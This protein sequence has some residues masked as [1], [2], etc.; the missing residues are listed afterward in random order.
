MAVPPDSVVALE[1]TLNKWSGTALIIHSNNCSIVR[2]Q[3]TFVA[4]SIFSANIILLHSGAVW[5]I[6]EW[7]IFS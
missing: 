2:E 6:L 5:G 4:R 7:L 3:V 1:G